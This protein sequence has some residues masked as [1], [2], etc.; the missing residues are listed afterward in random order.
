MSMGMLAKGLLTWIPGVQRGFF[1]QAAAVGTDSARYCY[2]VWMKHL[3][4]AWAHGMK[5]FPESVLELGP[6]ASVGTGVAALLSGAERYVA[7]DAVPHMREEA[8]AAVFRELV[9][10]FQDRAPRPKEGFPPFEQYLDARLFPGAILDEARL[11][12][13]LEPGRLDR[14]E[15]AVAGV[16]RAGPEAMI[17]YCTW[18]N[19]TPIADASIDYLFSHVVI[20]HVDDLDGIYSHCG[21]WV[22]PGGWMTHQIDFTCLNTAREWNGHLAYGELQWKLITGRRPYFVNRARPA[23]HLELMGRHGFEV[24]H[25]IRGRKAGGITRARLAPRWRGISDDDLATQTAFV[26]A[27]RRGG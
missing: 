7:I 21:R 27:R 3:T 12:A 17:R 2:G 19:L 22:R 15:Q 20:N 13:A 8:N 11:R 24:V 10:L 6:G 26:V 18:S 25:M 14:I 5:R 9:R 16:R 4:L 1:D 23:T